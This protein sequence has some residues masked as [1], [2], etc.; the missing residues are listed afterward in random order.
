MEIIKN[1]R[2][3]YCAKC[4]KEIDSKYK[5]KDKRFTFHMNCYRPWVV[6][7]VERLEE[8]LKRIKIFLRKLN[9]HDKEMIVEALEQNNGK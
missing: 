6:S 1:K 3:S 5:V 4:S 8:R 9:K 2:K 7:A